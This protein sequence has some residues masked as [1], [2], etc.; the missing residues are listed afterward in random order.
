[1]GAP[2]IGPAGK[3]RV[4]G[5]GGSLA[6][7]LFSIDSGQPLGAGPITSAQAVVVT[8]SGDSRRILLVSSARQTPLVEGILHGG[9]YGGT[10]VDSDIDFQVFDLPSLR[11]TGPVIH[12]SKPVG[13]IALS[14]DGR[15]LAVMRV[16]RTLTRELIQKVFDR[17]TGKALSEPQK[18]QKQFAFLD[19]LKVY[20]TQTGQ[21]APKSFRLP[22]ADQPTMAP[23]DGLLFSA[24]GSLLL[25]RPARPT[26]F[27]A[28]NYKLPPAHLVDAASLE[29]AA[30]PLRINRTS[31]VGT[32]TN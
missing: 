28:G 17:K 23:V 14:P 21:A 11:P 15:R 12:A 10:M 4:P 3:P 30:P 20:D 6:F 18:I 9:T 27:V 26:I 8:Y 2:I 19:D 25:V 16:G 29:P 32:Q 1:M 24:D 7:E 13:S 22:E 31:G 5:T